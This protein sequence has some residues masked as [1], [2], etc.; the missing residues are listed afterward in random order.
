MEAIEITQDIPNQLDIQA[1]AYS[2]YKS[3][4][5]HDI[6]MTCVA[7]NGAL[8]YSSKLY[9]G[10]T[11]ETSIVKHSHVLESFVAGD[12]IF[13]EIML[14]HSFAVTFWGSFKQAYLH[15][16]VCLFIFLSMVALSQLR[17][18]LGH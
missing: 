18:I 13:A 10:S 2:N 11:S 12:L 3:R 15:H 7:P 5:S 8:V 4:H 16:F 14:C 1:Q 9:P 6:A 17:H